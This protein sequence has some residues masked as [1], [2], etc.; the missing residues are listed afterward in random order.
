MKGVAKYKVKEQEPELKLDDV[1][2]L[3]VADG[4]VEHT[5]SGSND[6]KKR[7]VKDSM[8]DADGIPKRTRKVKAAQN[9]KKTAAHLDMSPEAG[10]DS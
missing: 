2:D 4:A 9:M 7:N 6:S 8:K 3:L 1:K 5:Y 10:P